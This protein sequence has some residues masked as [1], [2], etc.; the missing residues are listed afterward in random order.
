MGYLVRGETC[1]VLWGTDTLDGDSHDGQDHVFLLP[2]V[3]TL[4]GV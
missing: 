1:R 4:N 3:N 2:D